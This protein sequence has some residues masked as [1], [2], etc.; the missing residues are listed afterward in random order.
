MLS[1]LESEHDEGLKD[2]D[3]AFMSVDAEVDAETDAEAGDESFL[4]S[5]I[6]DED[7]EAKVGEGANPEAA[8]D[9]KPKGRKQ[10]ASRSQIWE[11]FT[12]VFDDKGLVKEGKCKYC[13]R[14]IQA[15][16]SINGTTA[17]RRHF[18]TCKRSPNK[19]MD[20]NQTT[21]QATPGD[22]INTWR[23]DAKKVRKAFAVMVMEDELPFAFGEKSGFRK[24]ISVACPRF[25]PPSR[26]TCTRDTVKIYLDEKCKLKKFFKENCGSVCV[27][28]DCWTSQQQDGYMVVTAHFIDEEWKYHKKI[29]KFIM[30]KGHKGK[31][32]GKNLQRCLMEWGLERVMTVTVDN[33]SNNDGSIVHLRKCMVEA[34]TSIAAGKFLHMR[35]AAHIVNL[36]VQDGLKEVE[37]SIKRVRAAVR[38]IKN[39]TSRLVKFKELALEE[40]V[41]SK[42]FLNL[43]VCTRWNSTYIMLKAAIT[44]AKVFT[45][46]YEDDPL[47]ALDLSE[48]KGGFGYP[49]E[50]DWENARKM[51][52]FLAHFY[53]LTVRVSSSLHVTSNNFLFEVG[54]IHILVQN[55]MSST[56]P[57]Q[58]AMAERMKEKFDKYWGSWHENEKVKDKGPIVNERG[59]GKKKEKEEKEKENLNL[60]IFIA[61]A[62][63]PRYKLSDFTRL[64]TLEIFGVESGEK[65]WY[66]VNKCVRELFEEY[67]VRLTTPEPTTPAIIQVTIEGGG[68]SM[69]K[70]LIASR[71]R[72]NNSGGS[73]SS[74]SELEKYL[75]EDSEDPDKKLTS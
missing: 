64:A 11:H 71:L 72:Q 61:A 29:I 49:D 40:K 16:T 55:W 10:M 27:T 62:L 22:G 26:R 60:L 67:R 50:M 13:G 39:G 65:V 74:I 33:A 42:A 6:E 30:V 47:Y 32:L 28:T 59:K 12:K 19:K 15:T 17:M 31:D 53:D 14:P 24:F 5:I 35:C 8:Q 69:M 44:Y 68:A 20:P 36:I 66:A 37:L 18:G 45:R 57:L 9:D 46:Y 58:K 25:S 48:E 4:R 21:L 43:D 54:N 23:Y 73:A 3:D 56:D 52:A 38:S 51:A 75:A 70:E 34:K 2:K 1:I 7:A 63:D 41:K